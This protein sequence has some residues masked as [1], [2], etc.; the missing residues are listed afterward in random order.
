MLLH[1]LAKN[2]ITHTVCCELMS[3]FVACSV[4]HSNCSQVAIMT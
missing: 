2:D 3:T 4:P 1:N